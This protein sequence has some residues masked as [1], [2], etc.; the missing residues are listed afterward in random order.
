MHRAIAAQLHALRGEVGLARRHIERAIAIVDG[1]PSEFVT[2]IRTAGAVLA[3]VERDPA[4]ARGHVEVAL[5]ELG[6]MDPLY[7]PPL[8][9]S[10]IHAEAELAEVARA[11]R[12]PA[13]AERASCAPGRLAADADRIVAARPQ[14]AGR[15]RAPGARPRRGRTRQRGTRGGALG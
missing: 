10:G 13:E 4:G 3:L 7:T 5:A 15:A 9:T 6:E 11:Q 1:L 14:R 8:L 12:R 2:P